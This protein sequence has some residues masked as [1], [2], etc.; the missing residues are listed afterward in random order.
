MEHNNKEIIYMNKPIKVLQYLSESN[1]NFNKRLE[2]IKN[3]EK[4]EIDWKDAIKLSRLWYCITVKKC[5]YS[6]E[7]YNRVKAYL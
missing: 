6:H 7:T 4:K 2:F 5:K 1:S 3:L